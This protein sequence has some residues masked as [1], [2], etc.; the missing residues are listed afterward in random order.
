[1]CSYQCLF[2]G[3]YRQQVKLKS[4]L[5]SCIRIWKLVGEFVTILS[6]EYCPFGMNT[7][8]TEY[9]GSLFFPYHQNTI[10]GRIYK[11]PLIC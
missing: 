10:T 4:I 5:W 9:I 2:A 3:K 1:M 7:T 11:L 8:Q 6:T